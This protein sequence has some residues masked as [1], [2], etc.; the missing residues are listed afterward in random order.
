MLV[1][2]YAIGSPVAQNTSFTMVISTKER[3]ET[4]K[5][6]SCPI[7]SRSLWYSKVFG[8]RSILGWKKINS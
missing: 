7:L 3:V 8:S 6:A 2:A 1:C 5:A 4:C